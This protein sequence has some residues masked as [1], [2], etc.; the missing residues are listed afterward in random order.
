MLVA[1]QFPY[2]PIWNDMDRIN[3][4]SSNR[5]YYRI[6]SSQ[7]IHPNIVTKIFLLLSMDRK[8]ILLNV[9]LWEQLYILRTLCILVP[10]EKYNITGFGELKVTKDNAGP[11]G[12]KSSRKVDD[13]DEQDD[14]D[15]QDDNK[16]KK[17]TRSKV[18]KKVLG[19]Q[20]SIANEYNSSALVVNSMNNGKKRSLT[21]PGK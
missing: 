9:P 20:T 6:F 13:Q 8:S 12:K 14:Q 16:T 17:R 3:L 2:S 19:L 7:V 21:S 15:N 4:T 5:N 11:G 10:K 18:V 1:A